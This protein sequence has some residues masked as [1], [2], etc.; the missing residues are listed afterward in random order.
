M[1]IFRWLMPALCAMGLHIG[2]RGAQAQDARAYTTVCD[3]QADP[4][5]GA[6]IA[7]SLTLMHGGK[8]Y[9]YM[10]EVGEVVIYEPVHYRFVILNDRLI[11]T[12]VSFSELRQILTVARSETET[13]IEELRDRTDERSQQVLR[14]LEFQLEPEF[15]VSR[16]GAE[17]Q[18][19]GEQIDY[20]VTTTAS[21]AP[22]FSQSYLEYA[23]WAAQLN[24]AL[25][26]HSQFPEVRKSVNEQMLAGREL[27]LTV[28][29]HAAID[30]PLHL[31]AEHRYIW[32]LQP[33]DRTLINKWERM[34]AS[35]QIRWLSFHDYQHA[36]LGDVAQ[37]DGDR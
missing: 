34:L 35:D 1:P 8:V 3:L 33:S 11:A 28:E 16:D 13:A 22:E 6:I 2:A 30:V 25:H 29:L 36:L 7:R 23:D 10:Q 21:P 15:R 17:I 31:R 19:V 26:P 32:D 4:A 5:G 37:R 20:H 12:S 24:F 18:M 27:P 14:A 9:D